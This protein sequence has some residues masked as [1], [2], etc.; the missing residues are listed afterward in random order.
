MKPNKD[1]IKYD[2]EDCY[3]K[4]YIEGWI[5]VDAATF[6]CPGHRLIKSNVL[7]SLPRDLLDQDTQIH[8]MFM[9][10][11]TF[12]EMAELMWL[13]SVQKLQRYVSTRRKIEPNRWPYRRTP[14]KMVSL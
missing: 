9:Y 5:G 8:E 12:P 4:G 2:C 7:K 10:G 14:K 3:G 6:A 13:D 11:Y 1:C